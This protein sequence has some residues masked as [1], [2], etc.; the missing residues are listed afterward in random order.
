MAGTEATVR[1]HRAD[2][3]AHGPA[4]AFFPQGVPPGLTQASASAA[5]AASLGMGA[6]SMRVL[7]HER[8]P[9]RAV[10][11]G[12][13][14]VLEYSGRNHGGGATAH[15]A[16]TR[17][18]V[19][20]L[21]PGASSSQPSELHVYET[22]LVFSMQQRPTA[23]TAA[24][25]GAQRSAAAEDTSGL[26][27]HAR[28]AMVVDTFGSKRAKM[29][30]R[31]REDNRRAAETIVAAGGLSRAVAMDAADDRAAAAAAAIPEE[32]GGLTASESAE[33]AS[34]RA[35]FPRFNR[36]A[37]TPELAFPFEGLFSADSLAELSRPVNVLLKALRKAKSR[38]GVDG[39]GAVNVIT[40][41]ASAGQL[42]VATVGN[43]V[44]ERFVALASEPG[45]GDAAVSRRPLEA[46]L[47][48]ALLLAV[49]QSGRSL[50]LPKAKP[51]APAEPAD[52]VKTEEGA[53]SSS[54]SSSSSAA[55]AAA[56][57]DAA[58]PA[59]A[60]PTAPQVPACLE[61]APA[62]V[63]DEILKKFTARQGARGRPTWVRTPQLQDRL[64]MH[65]TVAALWASRFD[66][67]SVLT[68]ARDL[69]LP[70]RKLVLTYFR[71]LGCRQASSASAALPA[72]IAASPED[73]A[74][75]EAAAAGGEPDYRITL[76]V[77][78]IFPPPKRKRAGGR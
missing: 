10:A 64:V 5:A 28:R 23:A 46:L 44:R 32:V 45:A 70:T 12:A 15:A 41:A 6:T 16:K 22:D 21:A 7:R 19:A 62:Q 63:A 9:K 55:A 27:E 50:R 13:N 8:K 78:L 51:V 42:P 3:R 30:K 59:P 68:L 43:F 48:V 20:V 61:L 35:V 34:R 47:L 73:A 71:Q 33:E 56:A 25:I 53:S 38:V 24:A 49:H 58:A 77:P 65:L 57:G 1:V 69:G 29:E 74:A 17:F 52:A 2:P 26:D 60:A 66:L 76:P 72:C 36:S 67:P 14:R 11:L 75:L 18:G 54:S 40:K 37:S 4:V 39:A 31:K